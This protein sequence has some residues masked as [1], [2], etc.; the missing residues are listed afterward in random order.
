MPQ[1]IERRATAARLES[2]GSPGSFAF[3][4]VESARDTVYSPCAMELAVLGEE[5]LRQRA[6]HRRFLTTRTESTLSSDS[7]NQ[8]ILSETVAP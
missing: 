8:G 7:Y 6:F 2:C 5:H 3:G 1:V 4:F